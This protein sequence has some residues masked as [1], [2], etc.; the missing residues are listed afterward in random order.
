MT[1]Y[2]DLFE[3]GARVIETQAHLRKGY[4]EGMSI[5][6][7]TWTA[8]PGHGSD[9]HRISYIL[10]AIRQLDPEWVVP[11]D[12]ENEYAT[13]LSDTYPI[14]AWNDDPARTS[15]QVIAVLQLAGELAGDTE[16]YERV[17]FLD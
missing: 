16:V 8:V 10:Q 11:D 17:S 4:E 15:E 12:P 1:T 14:F 7:C 2:K 13:R 6:C 9:N 5:Y 3:E